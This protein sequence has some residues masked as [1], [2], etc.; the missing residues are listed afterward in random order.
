MDTQKAP[1]KGGFHSECDGIQIFKNIY[2]FINSY[3]QHAG[4]SPWPGVELRPPGLGA[5]SL[6]HWTTREVQETRVFHVSFQGGWVYCDE[7]KVD[8]FKKSSGVSLVLWLKEPL[9]F[10]VTAW[11]IQMEFLL[12]QKPHPWCVGG[13]LV[14]GTSSYNLLCPLFDQVRLNYTNTSFQYEVNWLLIH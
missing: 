6:S 2:L 7:T 11:S 4:S 13:M 10:R 3:L 12:Y 5:R 8:Q 9:F 14:K 1:A